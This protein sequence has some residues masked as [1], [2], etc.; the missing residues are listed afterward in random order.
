MKSEGETYGSGWDTPTVVGIYCMNDAD[1]Q[2]L[3]SAV[4]DAGM[5][6]ILLPDV[7][8]AQANGISAPDIVVICALHVTP[9]VLELVAL[10]SSPPARRL[11]VV[12]VDHD[13]QSIADTLRAGADDFLP[14]PF[15]REELVVRIQA[16][17]SRSADTGE[18]RRHPLVSF[19]FATRTIASSTSRV[20]LS[21]LEWTLLLALLDAEGKPLGVKELSESVPRNVKPGSVI[22]SMSRLR[23]KLERARFDSIEIE[24]LRGVGYRVM[25]HH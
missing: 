3:V 16:I 22:S 7:R 18:A 9:E 14:F 15:A 24:T 21:A 10:A 17:L 19:D 12:S 5:H 2:P 1:T 11:L 20:T 8:A 4:I 6:P 13:P 25:L 23:R